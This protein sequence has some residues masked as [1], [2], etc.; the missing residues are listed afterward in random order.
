MPCTREVRLWMVLTHVRAAVTLTRPARGL[1]RALL[2][3]EADLR[4]K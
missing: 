4:A 3:Y 1:C 2:Y